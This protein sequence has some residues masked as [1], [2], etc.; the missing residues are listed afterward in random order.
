M[1]VISATSAG[2]AGRIVTS[3]ESLVSLMAVRAYRSVALLD[4]GNNH[5]NALSPTI[6]DL[7]N[8]AWP[9]SIDVAG[10]GT[11]LARSATDAKENEESVMNN[12]YTIETEAEFR[13][14]EWQRAV[15]ADALA[16]PARPA[17]G[18]ARWPRLGRLTLANLR[19]L[20]VPRPSVTAGLEPDC[21][22]VVC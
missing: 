13:R 8:L 22:S 15:E 11:R 14:R 2:C 9:R 18:R 1:R 10:V 3:C 5:P 4:K 17:N 19:R 12:W 20:P 6:R 16:A 21:R 7:T